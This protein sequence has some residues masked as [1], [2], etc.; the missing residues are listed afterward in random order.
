MS[1]GS[2]CC[3]TPPPGHH[4]VPGLTKNSIF[5]GGKDTTT[6]LHT[7]GG[8]WGGWV[9]F[10]DAA[11]AESALAT[12]HLGIGNALPSRAC[13]PSMQAWNC[14]PHS[15]SISFWVTKT[16]RWVIARTCTAPVFVSPLLHP[17]LPVCTAQCAVTT[18]YC[19]IAQQQRQLRFLVTT[20]TKKI[21]THVN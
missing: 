5:F 7:E 14:F 18:A 20:L 13:T 16:P 10:E 21:T 9:G 1:R 2:T 4:G 8:L 15:F 19:N 3:I 12:C 17:S 6:D 11:A